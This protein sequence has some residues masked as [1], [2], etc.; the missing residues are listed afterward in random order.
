MKSS[1]VNSQG[2]ILGW[3]FLD[4]ILAVN[5]SDSLFLWILLFYR[6]CSFIF[7]LDS[8]ILCAVAGL[9]VIVICPILQGRILYNINILQRFH[10]LRHF[11][12]IFNTW[13]LDVIIFFPLLTTIYIFLSFRWN[14]TGWSNTELCWLHLAFIPMTHMCFYFLSF[15]LNDFAFD[16]NFLLVIFWMCVSFM[17]PILISKQ[18]LL[19]IWYLMVGWFASIYSFDDVLDWGLFRF[20]ML[21]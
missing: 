10:I 11:I 14:K 5:L 20:M 15:N 4:F 12:E 13:T 2:S 6:I 3:L 16:R 7:F 19:V 21:W 18:I 17:K 1:S 8:A 9:S